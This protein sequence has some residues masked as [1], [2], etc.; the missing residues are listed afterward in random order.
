ME[1]RGSDRVVSRIMAEFFP[2]AGP[3]SAL[4]NK[5]TGMTCDMSAGGLFVQTARL[6]SDGEN[7]CL[8]LHLP[9]QEAVVLT[10]E[11]VRTVGAAEARAADLPAGFAVRL[12]YRPPDFTAYLSGFNLPE[13]PA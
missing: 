13:R 6:L 8:L 7:L 11:I 4:E 3:D 5:A 10:G 9:G 2:S 1:K 12:L